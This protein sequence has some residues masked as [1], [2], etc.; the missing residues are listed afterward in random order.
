MTGNYR[1]NANTN[2]KAQSCISWTPSEATYADATGNGAVD[3][4]DIPVIIHNYNQTHTAATNQFTE[5]NFQTENSTPATIIKPL[6]EFKAPDTLKVKVQLLSV[7]NLFGVAFDLIAVE[8]KPIKIVKSKFLWK[9]LLDM[10]WIDIPK[11]QISFG[12]VS[13]AGQ[14]GFSQDGIIAEA[15]F[16]IDPAMPAGKQVLIKFLN[17][18]A[19]DPTGKKM[20]MIAESADFKTGIEDWNQMNG[21]RPTD[22]SLEQ[23]FPNPFNPETTIQYQ[24]PAENHVVLK[25]FD[26]LGKEIITLVNRKQPVGYYKVFWNGCDRQGNKVPAGIYFYQLK[27][28]KFAETH[29]MI[30]LQ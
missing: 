13:R 15:T 27:S 22:F 18:Y 25:I 3:T 16:W 9:H 24:I 5:N 1:Q 6:V 21:L 28:E 2:W 14:S 20:E 12:I 30:L 11:S 4:L 8:L 23:N 26:M 17:V 19:I 10:Q 7:Q 29:K